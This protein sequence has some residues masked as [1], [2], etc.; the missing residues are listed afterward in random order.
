MGATGTLALGINMPCRSTI[1]CGDTLELNGLMFR[2]MSGRAGRRGFDRLGQVV[3]LDMAFLKISSLVASDLPVLA[4]E[5][6]M[7]PTTLL[8]ILHQMEL[9]NLDEEQGKALPRSKEDML[10]SI[11]PL[12]SMPFFRSEVADLDPQVAYHTRF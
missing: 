7:S 5:F 8:R 2:Q 10:R 1:F 9:V 11:S 4:G 6:N 3:F 12:F